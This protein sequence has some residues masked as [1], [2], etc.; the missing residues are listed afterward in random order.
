MLSKVP[1]PL[2]DFGKVAKDLEYSHVCWIG[3]LNGFKFSGVRLREISTCPPP[4]S[5]FK[6]LSTSQ[7]KDANSP[8]LADVHPR[9]LWCRVLNGPIRSVLKC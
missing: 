7:K 4:F 8:D 2:P 3:T 5:C 6:A 9:S 1:P